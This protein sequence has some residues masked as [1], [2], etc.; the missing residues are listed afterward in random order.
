MYIYIASILEGSGC[1]Y[2]RHTKFKDG[3]KFT[4]C[5]VTNYNSTWSRFKLIIAIVVLVTDMVLSIIISVYYSITFNN[6]ES[7]TCL[8]IHV[9]YY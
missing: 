2:S 1:S 4:G 8:Y 9:I 6:V 5:T 7:S 3:I